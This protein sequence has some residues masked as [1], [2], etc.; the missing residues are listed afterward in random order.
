MVP[1][2]IQILSILGVNFT[3][4][5]FTRKKYDKYIGDSLGLMVLWESN[6]VFSK[7]YGWIKLDHLFTNPT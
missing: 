7:I 2:Y 1:I 5:D 4:W 3:E 6:T